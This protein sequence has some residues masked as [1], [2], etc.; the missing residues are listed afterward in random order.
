MDSINTEIE[1]F[2]AMSDI[3]S[4]LNMSSG[5]LSII[6]SINNNFELSAILMIIAIMFDS[7]DGWV[8]R[9]RNRQDD[10]SEEHTS[11]LQSQ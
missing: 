8:A 9:K 3:I 5:F 11:E 6:C 4:L 1:S 10:R 7:V 2:I